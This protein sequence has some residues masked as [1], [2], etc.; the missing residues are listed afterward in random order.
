M[1]DSAQVL[2]KRLSAWLSLGA[3]REL[4]KLG[5]GDLDLSVSL[6]ELTAVLGVDRRNAIQQK[7]G[8]A[9]GR[10][11][12]TLQ[13]FSIEVPHIQHGHILWSDPGARAS[14]RNGTLPLQRLHAS[15]DLRLRQ[16]LPRQPNRHEPASTIC[17]MPECGRPMVRI[18]EDVSECLDIVPAEFFVHRHVRGKWACKCCQ[19]LS[20][21]PVDPQLINKGM[22]APGLVAQSTSASNCCCVSVR[23]VLSLAFG[24]MKPPA[25]S[26]RPQHQTPNP[27]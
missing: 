13:V 20:Q 5:G 25:L 8:D 17:L 3:L 1:L 4:L 14:A 9:G 11:I 22:P 19:T 15:D 6:G 21:A 18:G 2:G 23:A 10:G 7:R 24:H 16:P 26:R 12:Q 27:S